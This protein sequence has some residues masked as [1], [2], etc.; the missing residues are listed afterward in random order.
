MS[1]DRLYIKA[2][3]I[4]GEWCALSVTRIRI[5]MIRRYWFPVFARNIDII[6]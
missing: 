6:G 5:T 4:Q 1:D 3:D 2:A